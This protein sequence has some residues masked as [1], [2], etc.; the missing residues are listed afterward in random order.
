MKAN[1]ILD[2]KWFLAN[3]VVVVLAFMAITCVFIDGVEYDDTVKAGEVATFTVNVSVD[4]Q[5]TAANTRMVI[6][7]L[8]PKSWNA[9]QNTAVTYTSSEDDGIQT[10]SLIPASTN[11]KN[12]PGLT[13]S[14]AI[15]NRFGVGENVL[16]DMEWVVYWSDKTYTVNNG[17]D[18]TAAVLISAKAGMDNLK[19][20]PAFFLNHTNDGLGTD[21]KHFKIFKG[22]CFAV[23]DG[24]G[25]LIDFCEVHFNAAQPLTATKDDFITFSFQGDVADN[26]LI[27][28]DKIF[29]CATA[30]TQNGDVLEVCPAEATSQMKKQFQ[31]GNAY[32]ITLWPANYF[33][34]PEGDEIVKIEYAFRNED[35]TVEITD[36]GN[37]FVYT[38]KCQ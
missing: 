13:W 17:D 23:T 26:D 28:A 36:A 20:K 4:G 34:I 10:M 14:A 12:S 1:T 7:F 30:Y 22:N 2:R 3:M 38:F 16:D 24:A 5:E 37:A 15:R 32:S 8:A 9:A 25:D 18:L 33:N 29:L 19:F 11:P 21:D 35:G 31:Y 6:G 27:N